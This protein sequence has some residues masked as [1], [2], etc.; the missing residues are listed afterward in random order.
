[1]SG[2]SGEKH[3]RTRVHMKIYGE[4]FLKKVEKKSLTYDENMILLQLFFEKADGVSNRRS[5]EIEAF[6]KDGKR[7]KKDLKRRFSFWQTKVAKKK[8]LFFVF[9]RQKQP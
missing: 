8:R 2:I 3:N 5:A 9:L 6:S 1:M 7:I 4:I